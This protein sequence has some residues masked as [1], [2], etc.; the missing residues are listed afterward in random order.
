MLPLLLLDSSS[1]GML[2]AATAALSTSA[3]EAVHSDDRKSG[4]GGKKG[5]EEVDMTRTADTSSGLG[6]PVSTE[7]GRQQLLMYGV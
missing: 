2:Q 3:T 1:P 4:S 7:I 5:R 6:L